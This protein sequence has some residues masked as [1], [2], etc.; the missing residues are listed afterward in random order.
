MMEKEPFHDGELALQSQTGE[1]EAAQR[2]G[3]F[4]SER[5][6]SVGQKFLTATRFANIGLSDENNNVWAFVAAAPIPFI[7]G[8]DEHHAL[9]QREGISVPAL[10][11]ETVRPG[12]AIGLVGMDLTSARRFRLNG[13]IKSVD[14]NCVT[15]SIHQTCPNCA[16]YIQKRVPETSPQY[17]SVIPSGGAELPDTAK[18]LIVNADTFFVASRNAKGDHDASH[19][20]GLPGFVKVDGNTLTIPDYFGNSMFMTLGNIATDARAGLTFIDFDRGEQLCL[21]GSAT[22]DFDDPAPHD[23]SQGRF[24]TFRVTKWQRF[25]FQPKPGWK[26]IEYSRF[27]CNPPEKAQRL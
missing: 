26:L 17:S 8:P 15:I 4:I 5:L 1:R 6:T 3:R 16:K 25:P 12:G 24:W 27:N 9:I 2:S 11:W 22:L 19:R 20:G 7:H 18:A 10:F 13:I 23:G 14:V 21:T